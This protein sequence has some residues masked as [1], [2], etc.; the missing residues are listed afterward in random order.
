MTQIIKKIGIHPN[1]ITAIGLISLAVFI[2][3]MITGDFLTALI[4][5]MLTAILFAVLKTK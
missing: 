5:L 3:A 4:V 1:L 2:H